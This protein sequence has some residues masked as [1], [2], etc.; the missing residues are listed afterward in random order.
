M[1]LT[2]SRKF[3]SWF[4][5]ALLGTSLLSPIALARPTVAIPTPFE[6]GGSP[7]GN[8]LAAVVAGDDQDTAAAATFFNE[9]LNADPRNVELIEHAFI[10]TLANGDVRRAFDLADK[11]LAYAHNDKLAH[12]VL[13]VRD[14]KT[15][16]YAL[17][18]TELAQSDPDDHS[19]LTS[20]LLKAWAWVGS[21]NVQK[22]LETTAHL[23]ANGFGVFRD[24]HAALMADVANDVDEAQ[25][26]VTAAYTADRTTLRLVEA[27]GRFMS[28]H[29]HIDD[30]LKAYEEVDKII[31]HYPSIAQAITSLKAGKELP[32]LVSNAQEG[33][34]EVLYGLG[35][36]GRAGDELTS[37][38]YLRLALYLN[39][40]HD[41][42]SF[43]LGETYERIKRYE[44][45]IDAYE[46][47]PT[48]SPLRRLADL[49]IGTVLDTMG[50]VD[51]AAKH[52]KAILDDNPKDFDTLTM[53]GRIQSEQKDYAAAA[54]TYTKALDA[55]GPDV[56]N[57]WSLY[58]FRGIA[59][60]RQKKWP[61]AEADFKKALELSPDQPQVLNYLGYT[62]V[63]AGIHLDE[64]F[65][66]LRR[67]VELSPDDG[68]IVDSLGWAHYKLGHYE[69]ATKLLEHAV[70]LKPG[71]PTINDHLGDAYW[72]IGRKL[73]A[74]FQWNH[75]RDMK[76]DP[77]DLPRILAKIDKGLDAVEAEKPASDKPAEKP[78][79]KPADASNSS[80]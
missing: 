40:D 2:P 71:D 19:N 42:A 48:A 23:N 72:K 80:Q 5:T 31:P 20:S 27:Y 60:E 70:D 65:A 22:A 14:L 61:P 36:S 46:A 59:Y 28:R 58:Y 75:A 47:V 37:I 35:S 4:F 1:P 33:A 18:R 69:E 34:A 21:H 17:A 68:Y 10:A 62:W 43:T 66:M 38:I 12:L 77:E 44:Q 8:Y 16:Q 74:H 11:L 15:N 24:F 32:P 79:A 39:P 45:A 51:D 67:A 29:G 6:V 30:A 49:Q 56:V 63:D 41:T 55:A 53:L 57:P 73:E 78:A 54:G 13:G 3:A 25:K 26:R 64:A 76:P 50:R 7:E 9:V 52:V